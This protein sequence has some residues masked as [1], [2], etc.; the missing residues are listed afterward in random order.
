MV[1]NR[2]KLMLAMAGREMRA[3]NVADEAG[4]SRH[5]LSDVMRTGK[6]RTDTLG[7]IARALGVEPKDLVDMED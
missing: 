5:T 6:C 3:A 2:Q 1:I 4:L 7:K